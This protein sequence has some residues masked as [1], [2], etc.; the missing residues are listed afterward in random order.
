M[1]DKQVRKLSRKELLEIMVE[2]SKKIDI[3]ERELAL[4]NSMT[5]EEEIV[6]IFEKAMDTARQTASD[7]IRQLLSEINVGAESTEQPE[8]ESTEQPE[9]ET[10]VLDETGE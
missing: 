2:Q 8:A 7:Y 3:L 6:G 4:R 5:V 1:T 10:P 9:E